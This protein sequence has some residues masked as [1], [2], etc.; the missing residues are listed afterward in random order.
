MYNLGGE[1]LDRVRQTSL[2]LVCGQGKW[3]E[4]CIEETIELAHALQHKGV[5]AELDLWGHDVS[6]DWDWWRRQVVHHLGRRLG[7]MG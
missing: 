1:A 2:T 5:A 6:H 4:N 7:D 3:E